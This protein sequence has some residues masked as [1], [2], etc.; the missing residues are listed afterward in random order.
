MGRV[1]DIPSS[2]LRSPRRS[3]WV[4][5]G[6]C[7]LRWMWR[8]SNPRTDTVRKRFFVSGVPVT[9][10]IT[11]AAPTFTKVGPLHADSFAASNSKPQAL[12]LLWC[13]V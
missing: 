4:A 2:N 3:C 5:E 12:Q 9:P 11:R 6:Y 10:I 7:P 8:E 13:A 1:T